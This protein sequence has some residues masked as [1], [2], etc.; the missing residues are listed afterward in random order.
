MGYY[1]GP[2]EGPGLMARTLD[3]NFGLRVDHYLAID[4]Q[5]FVE[6]IDAVGGIDIYVENPIDLNEAGGVE[7]PSNYLSVGNH[8]LDGEL[9]LTLATDRNP[10][11]FQRARNQ[12]MILA[13]LR[14]KLLSPS[15]YAELPHLIATFSN[16]VLTD[17]SPNEI[18]KL[19]CIGQ[20]LTEENT[21]VVSFP[22]E[23]FTPGNIYDPYRNTTTF[24]YEA[25]FDLMRAYLADF[26]NG[27]WPS[28]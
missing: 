27:T 13:A 7:D 5:T 2:G 20:E 21:R 10:S 14:D 22:E 16:S 9:A 1:D 6:I 11:T 3:L 8:H 26:M 28:P 23:M 19:V 17:L 15:I 4:L 18:N 12:N 25:D 24:I